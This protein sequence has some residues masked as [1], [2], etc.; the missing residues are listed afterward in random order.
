M[1]RILWNNGW[2]L[3]KGMV[4]SLAQAPEAKPVDLP[5]DIMIREQK[6]PDTKNGIQTGFYPGGVYTCMKSFRVPVEWKGQRIQFFFEGIQGNARVYL[7]GNYATGCP[8]GYTGFLVDANDFLEYDSVNE[9]GVLIDSLEQSSR[10]YSG[11]GIYRNVWLLRGEK[12]CIPAEGIRVSTPEAET[13]VAVALVEIPVQNRDIV[14]RFCHLEITIRNDAGET[15]TTERV[16]VTSYPGKKQTVRQRMTI[17]SPQLW[18]VDSPTLYRCDVDLLEDGVCIDR[19]NAAFG[20]RKLQLDRK[21]GLRINGVPTKLRGAC[22]H[23]DH[24][25]VGAS[26][27]P[28][29]EE[30]KI[31]LLKEAGF[32]CIRNAHN[33]CSSALLEACD[34]LGM[35]V[36]DEL[37]DVWTL[38]KNVHDYSRDFPRHWEQAVEDM[39]RKDFNHPSVILYSMGN[40]L[41]EAGRSRGGYWNREVNAL[42]KKLDDT[43]YT[44]NA[45]NGTMATMYRD[46]P[47]M[48]KKAQSEL[49]GA[50]V[51]RVD[52]ENVEGAAFLNMMMA[53]QSGLVADRVVCLPEMD[54]ALTEFESAMDIA[55][56]NYMTALHELD[57]KRYP[58]RLL[59]AT[60]TYPNEVDRVWQNVRE[61]PNVLGEMT[62]TGFDYIGEA[63]CG[64]FYYDGTPNFAGHY[65]D[66]LAYIGDIDIT[67]YRRPMS[68]YRETVYGLREEP[69]IAVQRPEHFGKTHSPSPWLFSDSLN[70]WTW[71]GFEEKPIVVE[72]YSP[73]HQIALYCNDRLIARKTVGEEKPFLVRFQTCYE[74]GELTAV[75]FRDGKE[76]HRTSLRTAGA[77]CRIRARVDQEKVLTEDLVYIE[78]EMTD[79]LGIPQRT[80]DLD[81]NVEIQGDGTMEGLGSAD[82]QTTNQYQNHTWRTFEGRLLLAVRTGHSPGEITVTIRGEGC[83]AARLTVRTEERK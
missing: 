53:A 54:E 24:G 82:P 12:V 56:Y 71:P 46:L 70:S 79:L 68:Y 40:E 77:E 25:I 16:K 62:W 48:V 57:G 72:V 38:P 34:R 9:I 61:H 59:L 29:A 49:N 58:N 64:I 51:K 19:E 41:P 80:R 14:P 26:V 18:D 69:Y 5:Y 1:E 43:R 7:N 4:Y 30:R 73:D 65:P 33:P 23:H 50:E 13:D 10:W 22:I 15:V 60:E 8:Y 83:A 42:F 11:S 37:S 31:R 66:T 47:Q 76:I 45:A 17:D 28:A 32:N 20:I 3:T 21:Y 44:T 78:I 27:F 35:L 67:G 63:G 36:M 81:L 74:P 6:N 39:V 52:A 55:G 75:S 2:F